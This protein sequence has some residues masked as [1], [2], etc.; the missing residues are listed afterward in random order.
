M[1]PINAATGKE[2]KPAAGVTVARPAT[3]PV[4]SPTNL[5]F[6]SLNHSITI[7]VIAAKEAAMSV[8][9][10]ASEVI[11]STWSSLPALKPYQPNQRSAVPIAIKGMLFGFESL[12][13]LEPT[14]KTE[15]RAANPAVAWTT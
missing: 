12:Y 9:R 15:A 11:P 1:M 3:A 10:N 5:G 4:I 13:L 7:Q 8:L 6:V 14:K 2:T